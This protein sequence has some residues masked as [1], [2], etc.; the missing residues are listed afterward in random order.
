MSGRFGTGMPAEYTALVTGG[1]DGIWYGSAQ[2]LLRDGAAVLIM[3]RRRDALERAR[4]TLLTVFPG[5]QVK[6]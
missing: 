1:S 3:G 6:T 2:A 4:G 5:G